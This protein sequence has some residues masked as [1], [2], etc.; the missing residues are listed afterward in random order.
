MVLAFADLAGQVRRRHLVDGNQALVDAQQTTDR[1]PRGQ[2]IV[3]HLFG[4]RGAHQAQAVDRADRKRQQRPGLVLLVDGSAPVREPRFHL[5][6]S[7]VGALLVILQGVEAH[8]RVNE[9]NLADRAPADPTARQPTDLHDVHDHLGG[10]AQPADRIVLEAARPMDHLHTVGRGV[11]E[12]N[13]ERAERQQ[14]LGPKSEKSSCP[15]AT[16]WPMGGSGS[17]SSAAA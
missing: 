9:T 3:R 4:D 6:L 1:G 8:E 14:D 12:R 10:V 2:V 17:A 5:R 15:R 7:V 13:R 16:A 11:G